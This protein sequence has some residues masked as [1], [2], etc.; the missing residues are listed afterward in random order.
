MRRIYK[1]E[2][3][4]QERVRRKFLWLPEDVSLGNGRRDRRWLEYAT[5][6]EVWAQKGEAIGWAVIEFI[7]E[8]K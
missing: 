4:E 8:G 6:R 2:P 5:V 3:E 1:T 7:D